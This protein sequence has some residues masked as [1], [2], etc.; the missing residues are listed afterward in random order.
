MSSAC[1]ILKMPT[2]QKI[3]V[4]IGLP[5]SGK[6][7]FF[8]SRKLNPISSDDIRRQLADDP[9]NQTIH[10]RV[11][12]TVRYLLRHRI[13]IGRKVTYIDAT[14]LT[15]KERKQYFRVAREH[16]CD[17]EALFFDLPLET[18][19]ARNARR[20][21]IVPEDV[22]RKMA[23]KLQPPAKEEGFTRI[24]RIRK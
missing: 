1:F 14:S 15:R 3:V 24:R 11:F 18:C 23:L 22:M 9:T 4:A 6:S 5:G 16:D 12:A 10:G 20:D 2:R 7:T 13:A 21:R 17:V 8:A 19:L